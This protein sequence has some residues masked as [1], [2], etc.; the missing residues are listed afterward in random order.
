MISFDEEDV[1]T[2]VKLGLNGSQA[3]IYLALVSLGTAEVKKIAQTAGIDRGEVYRQIEILQQKALV[4]KVLKIPTAYKSIA[5]EETLRK[6]IEQKKKETFEMQQKV[7]ILIKKG[8]STGTLNE[9]AYTISI[10]PDDYSR[11]LLPDRYEHLQ[12]EELWYTQIENIPWAIDAW[13][14]VFKKAFARGIRLRVIAE[15]NQPTEAIL[16]LAQ[17]YAKENPNFIIRFVKPTLLTTI[18]IFDDKEMCIYTEKKTGSHNRPLLNTSNP[19][20]I[21]IIKNYFELRWETATTEYPK[22]C[23]NKNIR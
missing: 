8:V 21:Q 13:S 6:L 22:K 1:Q 7:K 5:L 4:E 16:K 15:L 20:L 23:T 14:E 2:L 19:I 17:S 10:L 11:R 3:K 9:E 18:A 12:K